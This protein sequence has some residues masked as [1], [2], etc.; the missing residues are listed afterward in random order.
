MGK[1]DSN[2]R[3]VV[4]ALTRRQLLKAGGILIPAS[5]AVPGLFTR[6]ARA[7]AATGFDYYISPTGSDANPGTVSSPWSVTAINSKQSL[8]AGKRVGFLPG[9]Y[10]VSGLMTTD[11]NNG[12]RTPVM[13]INGGTSNSAR[14]YLA[15][16]DGGGNYSP[17]TA[18][19]DAKG[20][21]GYYGGGNANTNAILGCNSQVGNR[22]YWTVD[23][24]V[25]EGF[26]MWA[27]HIGDSPGGGTAIN[28]WTIQNCEITGGNGESVTGQSGTNFAPL[29]IYCSQSGG[30]FTNNYVH[31]NAGYLGSLGVSH[32]SAIYIWGY[33]LTQDV[34]ISYNTFVATGNVHSKE[35]TQQNNTVAYNYIDMR[36][37]SSAGGPTQNTAG[38]FGFCADGGGGTL[39]TIHHNIVLHDG[40]G[41]CL[42]NDTGQNGWDTPVQI[43]NNTLVMTANQ[44]AGDPVLSAYANSASVSPM[45]V[46]AYNNLVYDGGYSLSSNYGYW[47]ANVNAFSL[48][49]YNIYGAG[50]VYCL[51]PAGQT[52]SSG[53]TTYSSLSS[54]ASAIGGLEKHSSASGANPFTNSGTFAGQF[55]V[56]AGSPAYQAGRVGGV[57]TGAACNVG[58]WD[59]TA[60]QIGCNF[61]GGEVVPS[62]PVLNSVG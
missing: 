42:Q 55:Q 29:I 19:F 17:R 56:Q 43:Y 7:Q 3:S 41:I 20:A 39:S 49:D 4:H 16:C 50:S 21:S 25:L 44:V 33:P 61:V 35:A 60:G 62:P 40:S 14:T 10:D 36:G 34:V 22:G 13:N 6:L 32:S 15:S 8:Y 11:A 46:A 38:I 54:W 37:S 53:E 18:V 5:A 57:S 48:C 59:G 30:L 31:D 51:V 26:S 23:G 12:A 24:V 9:T 47:L 58:A 45:P 2:G 27:I 52:T 1:R 28:D